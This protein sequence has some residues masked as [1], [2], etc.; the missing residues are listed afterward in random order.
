MTE[1]IN[2]HRGT[3]YLVIAAAL[4]IIIAGITQAQSVVVLFLVSIFLAILGAPLV[5]WLKRKRLPSL[6]AVL[7]VMTGMITILLIAG[8]L[9]GASLNSFYNSL[10]F[11][12]T[13]IQEQ[14][15]NFKAL[16]ASKG[17]A[18]T[19]KILLEYFNPAAVMN[20]TAGLLAGLSAVLSN[21]VLILLT[22]TFILLEVSSFPVKLRAILGD[23]LA[24]FPQYKRFVT[25][26][27]R[28]MVMKTFISLGSG[29]LI[30][31]WLSL[32]GVDF[33]VLWGFL[34]FLLNYVPNLG[35]IIAAVP[36]ILLAL[37][38]FGIGRALLATAGYLAVNFILENMLEPRLMGR[39]LGLS[40][41]VVF[42]SLIF[43]GSLLGLIG[44]VLSIPL[45]MIL[46]LACES[47]ESTRW[48]AVMLGPE[49]ST[50]SIPLATKKEIEPKPNFTAPNIPHG[51]SSSE[52][53]Q[54]TPNT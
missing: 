30:G 10:P 39:R 31:I 24:V 37:I 12:Q 48:L 51:F 18:V 29:I 13:R 21:I 11:Y 6:V 19:D 16:L 54:N 17:I 7:L 47:N 4:V 5:L 36:A 40:A 32:I 41:L 43:W 45:T 9:V 44:M 26:I 46:K 15:L 28:Y 35:S 14:L 34:A 20:L 8:A 52:L 25:D 23:P 53:A 49:P 38:Q 22:V 42:L 3:R 27:Q 50:E 1:P 2:S 33:P